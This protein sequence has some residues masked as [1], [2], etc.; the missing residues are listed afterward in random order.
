MI[1]KIVS[2]G[3]T[4]VDRGALDAALEAEF[5]C[6]GWCPPG[7]HAEDGTIDARYPLRCLAQGGYRHRTRRNVIDSDGTFII[8][9]QR[10]SGGTG[11][12]LAFCIEQR[13]PFELIDAADI[14]ATEL[15][16]AFIENHQIKVLNV[17][18]PRE[19]GWAGG[20]AYAAKLVSRYL[21]T[22]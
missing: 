3:Q 22:V 10:L 7:R 19:S 9:H 17:A 12:T 5:P 2:G 1:E 16:R 4:G 18:G 13:K 14:T 6:G 20:R 8:K 21:K 15:L 11:L